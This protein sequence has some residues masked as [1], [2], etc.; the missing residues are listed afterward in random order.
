MDASMSVTT[1]ET[2]EMD[3]QRHSRTT[4]FADDNVK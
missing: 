2:A 1:A 3:D 4:L